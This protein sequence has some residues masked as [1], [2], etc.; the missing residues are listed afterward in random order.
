[1]EKSTYRIIDA[2]F[3]R[4]REGFRLIEEFCRF[5]LDSRPLTAKCKTLR[6]QLSETAGR[7]DPEKL[8]ASRD[9]AGDIGCGLQVPAQLKRTGL[10]DSL[11]AAFARIT[12]ALRVIS[13][14]IAPDYPTQAAAIEQIRYASYTLQ[15]EITI[16][17]IPSEKFRRVR[18]YCLIDASPDKSPI[19]L[20][21]SLASSGA[22]CLQLRAKNISDESFLLTALAFVEAC[23]ENGVLSIIND[24]I[25]IACASGADGVHLGQD[26][27][28][29]AQCRKFQTAPLIIGKST[30][31][32]SELNSAIKEAPTYIATGSVFPTTTKA[33]VEV[34]GIEY[35]AQAK[36]ILDENSIQQ[37]AIGGINLNNVNELVAVGVKTIA[38]SSCL[39]DSATPEKACAELKKLLL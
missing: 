16:L 9:T 30:H 5:S 38:V 23:K 25:D 3:N 29:I 13:E 19:A 20:A 32:I 1:M 10:Q 26:D 34:S 6:H 17:A 31:S 37:V 21:K 33:A 4:S 22:D 7:L 27:L 36:K 2:N 8:I 15:K 35:T 12:E 14:L 28:P 39:C 24:R 18:L 11:A